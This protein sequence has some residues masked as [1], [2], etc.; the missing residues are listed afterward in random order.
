[1]I[2]TAR[3]WPRSTQEAVLHGAALAVTMSRHIKRR[4]G[5]AIAAKYHQERRDHRRRRDR[6]VARWIVHMALSPSSVSGADDQV[7]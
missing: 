4:V 2:G 3:S 1:M 5:H 7:E 6:A